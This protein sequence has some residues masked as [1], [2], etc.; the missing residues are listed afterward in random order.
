MQELWIQSLGREDPMEKEMAT[1]SIILAWQ[2]PWTK[3]PP[4]LE[5]M[6]SPSL[7]RDW[8]VEPSTTQD[9][10]CDYNKVKSFCTAEG[11]TNKTKRHPTEWQDI[12]ANDIS[13]KRLVFKICYKQM[14]F[15]S[16]KTNSPIKGGMGQR[17][18]IDS[19]PKNT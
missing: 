10:I 4:E 14:Q 17:S 11:I 16:R 2:T 8:A 7:P 15:N 3:E 18:W 12:F 5:S 6:G 19:F 1:H 9:V 13:T